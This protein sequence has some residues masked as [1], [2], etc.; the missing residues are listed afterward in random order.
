MSFDRFS[1]SVEHLLPQR[2][3]SANWNG[4][5]PEDHQKWV[6][7]LGNIILVDTKKNS[8]LSNSVFG[9]KKEKYKGSI[10]NR[11]NTNWVFMTYSDWNLDI[12][13]ENHSRVVGMLKQY[14]SGH[15][16][17]TLRDIQKHRTQPSLL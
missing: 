17:Q 1:S 4:L 8:S 15:S 11:A 7:R 13:T 6:H 3:G 5:S 14:Y 2:L 10:E 16:V 9:Q 12:L